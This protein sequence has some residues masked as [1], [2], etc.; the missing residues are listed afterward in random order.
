MISRQLYK[1]CKTIVRTNRAV[2]TSAIH[3]EEPEH[4]FKRTVRILTDDVRNFLKSPLRGFS[5]PSDIF[6]RHADILIIGGG[7]V[8]SSIAYFLKEKTGLRGVNIVVIEKDTTYSKCSTVLSVGG[9]RQQ[10]SLPENIQMSLFGAEFLRSVK[11]RFGPDS[12][13]YFTPNGYLM[14]ATE[15]GA[16]QLIDNSK[17]QTELGAVNKVLS[18]RELKE[19]FPWMEVEDVEAGCLGLEK[20]GWF[21][22]WALLGMLKRG[23]T[24]MGTQ[25][26][27]AEAVGFNFEDQQDVIVDGQLTGTYQ[28]LDSVDVKLPDGEVKTIQFAYCVIAAGAESGELAKLAKIGNGEGMLTVPLPVERRKRYVYCFECQEHGPG[29]NTPMTIDYTGAYFRRDGLGGAFIAG[30]SPQPEEEPP[31]T[32]LEVDHEFFNSRLWPLLAQRVPAFNALKVRSSWAGYYDYNMFDE[33]GIIGAHPYLFNLY[34]ATGFSGHGIQ[35]APAVGRAVAELI[36]DGGFQT[37]D[38]TRL[39]FDRLLID[40]PMYEVCIV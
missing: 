38:L 6:P 23:A 4:P 24:N 26:I 33:N 7:A 37:I 5:P 12:D 40:K 34:I 14:L 31:T 27:N 32:N 18:K 9:L 35:Q 19:R 16:Q 17:I 21:D 2:H 1:L 10:F 8:G 11:K 29:L 39:G 20:E 13:V 30:L 15:H 3:F 25:Y 36:I 22:P 28:R